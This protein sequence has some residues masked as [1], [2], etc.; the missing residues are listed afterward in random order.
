ML[1]ACSIDLKQSTML[2]LTLSMLFYCIR[3]NACR[4][5]KATSIQ[6]LTLGQL[7]R[8]S[9][10]IFDGQ[11][12]AKDVFEDRKGRIWTHYQVQINEIWKGK[13]IHNTQIIDIDLLGGT[14]GDGIIKRRHV[15]HGQ[16]YLDVDQRGVFFL[17][18]SAAGH[19]VFTGLSQ[20]FFK[21][22]KQGEYWWVKRDLDPQ[23]LYGKVKTFRLASAPQTPDSLSLAELKSLVTKGARKTAS[24][25]SPKQPVYLL[26]ASKPRVKKESMQQQV[27][28]LGVE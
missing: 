21:V 16:V 13:K 17:E 22:V 6:A 14:L 12:I 5:A 9:T 27:I 10:L 24:L 11:V 20:G 18:K 7:T 28:E 25:N 1:K 2:L 8:L 23:H 15:I 26:D 4:Q 19:Y 3:P